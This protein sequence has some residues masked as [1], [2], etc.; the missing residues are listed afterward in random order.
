[1]DKL[2]VQA[3][4]HLPTKSGYGLMDSR[5]VERVVSEAVEKVLVAKLGE[6]ELENGMVEHIEQ[7]GEPWVEACEKVLLNERNDP[8]T[9]VVNIS[10]AIE[11]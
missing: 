9:F 11:V 4:P 3:R 7:A 8:S 1:M 6:G 2:A 5:E 10:F